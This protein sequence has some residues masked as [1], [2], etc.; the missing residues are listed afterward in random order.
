ML[1]AGTQ[2]REDPALVIPIKRQPSGTSRLEKHVELVFRARP[3]EWTYPHLHRAAGGTQV[4]ERAVGHARTALAAQQ[5]LPDFART[6]D[7]RSVHPHRHSRA[8]GGS[9]QSAVERGVE[10]KW[11]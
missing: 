1:P 8:A 7:D 3:V 2:Q 9:V 10:H 11:L 6:V 4:P 5:R